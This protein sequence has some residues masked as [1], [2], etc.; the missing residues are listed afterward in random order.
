M[1]LK[2]GIEFG[3]KVAKIGNKAG[4]YLIPVELVIAVIDD[5]LKQLTVKLQIW[6]SAGQERFRA[7]TR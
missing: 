4:R 2:V 7:V 5:S 3:S 1:D 6:D